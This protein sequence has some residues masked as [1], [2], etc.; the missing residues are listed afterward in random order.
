MV[1]SAE[2]VP[3]V[4]QWLLDV[5]GSDG[6]LRVDHEHIVR[7]PE[8]WLIP[9]NNVA[10]LDGGQNDQ[11]IFPPPYLV[12]TEPDGELRFAGAYPGTL[13]IPIT[14]PDRE[15]WEELIDPEFQRAGFDRFGVPKAV[16]GGWREI[17]A[18][19]NPTGRERPNPEYRTGPLRR[20]YPPAENRLESLL[21]FY[22]NGWLDERQL[23]IGLVD[24][25]VYLPREPGAA[26]PA[27][28]GAVLTVYT[29]P[30]WL[31]ADTHAW[32]R[33]DLLGLLGAAGPE[34]TVRIESVPPVSE[35]VEAAKI[36]AAAAEFPRYAPP[37][38]ENGDC[39]EIAPDVVEF[40]R[41][42][43]AQ[44]GVSEPVTPVFE[45]RLAR[46]RG[47]ELTPNECRGIVLART[48]LARNK[49]QSPAWPADLA[50]NGLVPGRFGPRPDSFGKYSQLGWTGRKIGWHRVVGA[51]VGFAL[52]EAMATNF[53]GALPATARLA[54]ITEA[55]IRS[56]V[57]PGN[58]VE[59]NARLLTDALSALVAPGRSEDGAF[60]LIGAL[61]AVL[62]LHCRGGGPDN[63]AAEP[64][65]AALAD[66]LGL[67]GEPDRTAAVYTGLLFERLL[68]QRLHVGRAAYG[69]VYPP[70]WLASGQ[71]LDGR[72][73]AGWD[74]VRALA[75]Q[76]VLRIPAKGLHTPAQPGS[77]GDGHDVLSALGRALAA[78]SGF[79]NFPADA[80][81]RAV[82]GSGGNPLVAA[83]AGAF[84]GA[85]AGIPGLPGDLLVRLDERY[86]LED[87]ASDALR[88]METDSPNAD[89]VAWFRRYPPAPGTAKAAGLRR[90]RVRGS[91]LGGAIGDAL[92]APIEFLTT[93]QIRDKHGPAG[94]TG[95]VEE[96]DGTGR[97][98]D[99]TQMTLF[100]A[101]GLI[102]AHAQARRTGAADVAHSL[103][104][105]YQRW[106]HTQGVAW[107]RARGPQLGT[108]APDGWL[109]TNAGLHH[110]RAPGAT[111]FS[112]LENYGRS[113]ESG[114]FEHKLNDSKGCGGVMRAAPI[115]LW[116]ADPA[117]VF[118]LA[119]VSAALTHSHPSGY[120]S[121]GVLAVIV[122]RL[123]DG[124]T[125]LSA[126]DTAR[127]EL[128]TWP[129]H[130]E[131]LTALDAAV[132]LAV[133]GD[134]TPEKVERL[135]NGFVGESALAIAVYAA[136]V[137]DDPVAALLISVNHSGDSDSTGAVCGNIVG[138]RDG[139]GWTY[140]WKIDQA[141]VVR[142][143]ADDLAAEFGEQPPAGP[144]WHE[145]YPSDE[146]EPLW[147]TE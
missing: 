88:D 132:S 123:I 76:A 111:C 17:G 133:E 40:A 118:R 69:F 140:R 19:N 14:Y 70:L 91:L 27:R 135:G 72:T 130:A 29:A 98:T 33:R 47:Y 90:D 94:V 41:D 1:E 127:A 38:Q 34:L 86:D 6:G 68:E 57:D 79:E 77:I 92:G 63:G 32:Q 117:E 146:R 65:S 22:N 37:V 137:T 147:P 60:G 44:L 30:K 43:A 2:A 120:L 96:S 78:V 103:Q 61:P 66:Y 134:P 85:R 105:A 56:D 145:R 107:D 71:V 28:A 126:I 39:P 52:G 124:A 48:W 142:Q 31:P 12:V 59:E 15:H 131:Q 51:Y 58:T 104:L 10:Y 115:A 75:G 45:A 3:K 110:R 108:D 122:R 54:E 116:S 106:L 112:S 139:A 121:A 102:R 9:Y 144:D 8:G 99:D 100:T 125:L 114:T 143:V 113:G 5:Y 87:L 82:N 36:V 25:D 93:Q 67:T 81:N 16:I 18:D 26:E 24:A 97:I 42:A 141:T 101:E 23:L 7:S 46:E 20:G 129:E 55:L 119:A 83:L 136:L 73:G 50:A 35:A 109:V 84:V 74:A 64:A 95:F 89:M 13:S 11:A 128:V 4:E 62:T 53:Q 21:A 138:A 49:Q 80:L